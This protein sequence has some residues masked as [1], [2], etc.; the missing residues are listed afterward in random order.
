V[1][2]YQHCNYGGWAANFAN[3][4]DYPL[5]QIA[6]AGG[7]NDDASS[8]RVAAGY[9]VTLFEHDQFQGRSVVLTTDEPCLVGRSFNDL[10]SSLRIEPV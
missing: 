7:V 3:A 10:L 9:R 1:R 4:G 6:G 8:I 2:L 5:P